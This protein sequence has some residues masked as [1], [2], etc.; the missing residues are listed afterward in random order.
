MCAENI[1]HQ[2]DP[3]EVTHFQALVA[4]VSATVGLG[5]IAGVAIAVSL[6]GPGA[7]VWMMIAGFFGMSA[8][9]AEVTLGQKY[10]HIDENGKVSGGAFHYLKEGLS[11]MNMPRLGKILSIIFAILCIGGSLGAGNM[12]QSNQAVSMLTN[13]F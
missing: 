6:G 9:F 13:S 3:G 10:R 8:K 1:H 4:A 2:N 12:F 7:V 5:N 11:E